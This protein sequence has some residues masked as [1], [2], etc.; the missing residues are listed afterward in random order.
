MLATMGL[1]TG[2]LLV[3]CAPHQVPPQA[4]EPAQGPVNRE[5]WLAELAAEAE[6]DPTVAS[7]METAIEVVTVR[8]EYVFLAQVRCGPQ[9]SGEYGMTMQALLQDDDGS[10]YDL[11][12]TQCTE[13]GDERSFYF[14]I[15]VVYQGYMEH[16]GQ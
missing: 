15:D 7:S 14:N 12:Q 9:L 3:A 4:A 11:L 6:R 16:F 8:E 10:R 1:I 13:G 5:A 2:L